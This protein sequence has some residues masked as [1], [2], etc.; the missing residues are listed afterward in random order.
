MDAARYS[1]MND[2]SKKYVSRSGT[3]D[4]GFDS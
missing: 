1:M 2:E 3:A 4:K